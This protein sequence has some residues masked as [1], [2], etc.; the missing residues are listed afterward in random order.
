MPGGQAELGDGEQLIRVLGGAGTVQ[1][2]AN[3]QIVL[4]GGRF[5][6]LGDIAD[7]RDGAAEI[8]SY[9]LLNGRSAISFGGVP[10]ARTSRMWRY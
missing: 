9:R 4:P 7:V 3:T 5:A 8:R 1:Q 6:R 2:L 10:G